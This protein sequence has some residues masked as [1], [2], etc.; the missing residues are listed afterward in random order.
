MI[1]K[2][3]KISIL[4]FLLLY[5]CSEG[6][7]PSA[8][9]PKA[10]ELS[11]NAT[12]GSVTASA[13]GLSL[14]AIDQIEMDEDSSKSIP[15]KIGTATVGSVRIE[16]MDVPRHGDVKIDESSMSV[17]YSPDKDFNGRDSF[18]VRVIDG[19][20][21]S[22]ARP[23]SVKVNPVDDA[24]VCLSQ[25][26]GAKAATQVRSTIVCYDDDSASIDIS[27]KTPPA[28][29]AVT[30]NKSDFIYTLAEGQTEDATFEVIARADGK[31]SAP[32][33]IRISPSTLGEKPV[34]TA[35]TI[36]CSEDTA[37]PGQLQS[38]TLRPEIGY[39]YQLTQ[40][41]S[42]VSARL[43]IASGRVTITSPENFFGKDE[44]KFKVRAGD[45]WSDEATVKVDITPVNDRPVIA[46]AAGTAA[47]ATIDEDKVIVFPFKISDVES[48]IE[49]LAVSLVSTA[50]PKNGK[51]AVD[52][53]NMK[54]SYTPNLNYNGADT[55]Q[56]QVCE[57]NSPASC[58]V[59]IVMS[60][61]IKPVNDAPY[62]KPI[63]LKITE[64][65]ATEICADLSAYA[66]DVDNEFNQLKFNF[67]DGALKIVSKFCFT[68]EPNFSGQKNYSYT[69]TDPAGLSASSTITVDVAGTEDPTTFVD[70]PLV[71]EVTEETPTSCTVKALDEDGRVSY[72]FNS[73][74]NSDWLIDAKEFGSS[75][76]FMITPPKDFFGDVKLGVLASGA[77][78]SSATAELLIK[79]KNVYDA[80]IWTFSQ[81]E[82]TIVSSFE[83]PITV[84][85]KA[86]SPDKL[87][88]SYNLVT[89]DPAGACEE[90]E[91]AEQSDGKMAFK[92]K[93]KSNFPSINY[94]VSASDGTD[95]G[96]ISMSGWIE[97]DSPI[98]YEIGP[99]WTKIND[100]W[101][102]TSSGK[103]L[104]TG[105][106]SCIKFNKP[107]NAT[108]LTF[109]YDARFSFGRM[110]IQFDGINYYYYDSGAGP[111]EFS[112]W[113]SKI[114]I[115]HYAFSYSDWKDRYRYWGYSDPTVVLRS[116]EIIIKS[117][118]F[119]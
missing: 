70:T 94:K 113:S 97:S 16:I 100:E 52:Q 42:K 31:E 72:S 3:S 57:K 10:S 4:G 96:T 85:Y 2:Y 92:F 82:K 114:S 107:A 20:S 63:S 21:A 109:N 66:G 38:E 118:K 106:N 36:T 44:L 95:N 12:A 56:V 69:V 9:P 88:M 104:P 93:C 74:L 29:G 5:G 33:V 18:A 71:C 23:V 6:T 73:S 110:S 84:M 14:D 35:S 51:V 103:G 19:T 98:P 37:C 53:A 116:P 22:I 50:K 17:K 48:P 7:G 55:F 115:C 61:T 87:K 75:G 25:N 54:F 64:D 62:A 112:V 68:P 8:S 108:K 49:D 41:P 101:N 65:S 24:P 111:L 119:E 77:G 102:E 80:P 86:E 15:L 40:L 39:Y 13:Q 117:I 43:D 11:G 78:T 28:K 34:A 81:P 76:T 32:A 60:I 67:G 47:T 83:Q 90:S 105:S 58:S 91:K 30:L 59:P 99:Y 26:F 45:K 46:L 89:F 79:V 27:I 1:T